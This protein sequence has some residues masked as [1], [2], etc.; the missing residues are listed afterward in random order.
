M[1]KETVPADRLCVIRLE[2]GLDWSS[3]CPFLG[4]PVPK[5]EY[6]DRNEPEKFQALLHEKLQ[7]YINAA[8]MKCGAV[9][10]PVVGVVGWLAMKYTPLALRSF[11]AV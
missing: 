8:M 6:P 5:D 10:V 7:P 11:T 4:V 3:I 1:V 9:V 2:D